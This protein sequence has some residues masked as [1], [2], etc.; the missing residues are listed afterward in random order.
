MTGRAHHSGIVVHAVYC[1]S[2]EYQF[3]QRCI[4]DLGDLFPP[5]DALDRL[6]KPKVLLQLLIVP[7][8]LKSKI[9][10]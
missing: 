4:V 2:V 7:I 10:Y 5:A 3:Q 1:C 8:G 6:A 9:E